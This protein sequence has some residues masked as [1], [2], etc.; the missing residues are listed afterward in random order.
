MQLLRA[1]LLLPAAALFAAPPVPAPTG[2]SKHVRPFVGTK[3]EGNTY[4]GAQVPFGMVALSPDTDKKEYNTASGYEYSDKTILGFSML[5]LSGT[6]IPDMGDILFQPTVGETRLDPGAKDLKEKGY[7]SRF[8]HDRESASPGYYSVVLDDYGVKAELT[9]TSRAGMLR[10]TYPAS[11]NAH[12]VLDLSHVLLHKVIW[13]N[14]RQV[15]ARTLQGMHLVKGWAKDRPVYFAAR[16]SKPF[17]GLRLFSDK[18]ELKYDSFKSYRYLSSTSGAGANLQAVVDYETAADEQISVKVGISALSEE[19]ALRNLDTEMPDWA[20]ESYVQKA[21][22]AWDAELGKFEVEGT[23]TQKTT[24]YSGVYHAFMAPNLYTDSDGRYRGQ[25]QQAKVAKGFQNYTTF[26][27]WDTYRATH[28]LFTLVQADRDRDMIQS[29]LAAYDQS[30]DH[31]LPIWHFWSNETWCMPGYHAVPVIVDAWAKG[32]TGI[33]WEKALDACV[34]S[35]SHPT[36]DGLADYERLGYVP[37]DLENESVSKTLEYA[38]DD[39]CIARLARGLGKTAIAERFEKRAQSYRNL[40]DP[41]LKFMRPKDSKGQW[42]TPF[43]PLEYKHLGPFTEGTTWQYTWSVAQDVPGL[44]GLM[45]GRDAFTRK[46]DEVFQEHEKRTDA[47]VEDIEGRIGEYWHG[48]EPSHHV[49]YLFAAAGQPWKTQALVRR[50]IDTQYGDQPGSLCGNDDC[51]QMSS[52]YIFSAMGFYPMCPGDNRYVIGSPA[53]PKVSMHLSNG[54]TFTVRAEKFSAGNVYV[55]KATLNGKPWTKAWLSH[56]NITEGGELVFT[57]GPKP[58][59]AWASQPEAAPG[60][61][62][63]VQP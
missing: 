16:F 3:G 19:A 17:G 14:V 23:D 7:Q 51:G 8:S 50:L 25:D 29:L 43:N 33:N 15:D 34:A 9:A 1:L 44:I 4:P 26:S 2:L 36:F 60:A 6:G 58:N 57:L 46:L 31:L 49:A 5:H 45:G 12:V 40:Y 35:A 48:N 13:S 27:L 28:P 39:A 24:F 63:D 56:A 47:G 42:M 38:Y 59:K 22:A 30:A 32:M 55:Q 18:K 21:R 20:F 52:W 62:R 54:R 61:M 11:K 53:L 10:F 37:F 41:S